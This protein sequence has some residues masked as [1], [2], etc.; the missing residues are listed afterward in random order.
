VKRDAAIKKMP[1]TTR[2][3]REGNTL[4]SL[5]DGVERGLR[6]GLVHKAPNAALSADAEV[7]NVVEIMTEV[8]LDATATS[9]VPPGDV[10]LA[11]RPTGVL[12][13]VKGPSGGA[14]DEGQTGE[15]DDDG[16]S[17]TEVAGG[18]AGESLSDVESNAG[19]ETSGSKPFLAKAVTAAE[20]V[21]LEAKASEGGTE[22][23]DAPQMILYCTTMKFVGKRP[24]LHV[25]DAKNDPNELSSRK[26]SN[27]QWVDHV[28]DAL[29]CVRYTP[30]KALCALRNKL[31]D[32]KSNM[33]NAGINKVIRYA[34]YSSCP[35][36]HATFTL[37]TH[38]QAYKSTTRHPTHHRTSAWP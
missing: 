12:I 17:D 9:A 6:A 20:Q 34:C 27:C 3:T 1:R 32:S 38:P 15:S 22:Q 30:N 5:A 7:K 26:V 31:V 28:P 29:K 24:V 19:D 37:P 14:L 2:T 23:G 25:Y 18:D 8:E 21:I 11:A 35:L 33:K 16:G 4:V 13:G 36:L 10:S